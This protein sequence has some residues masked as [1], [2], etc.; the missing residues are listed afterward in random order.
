M[1]GGEMAALREVPFGL[2]Y[3]TIDATPLFIVLAGMYYQRT[4]D[5]DAVREI[6]PATKR[7]LAW[8]DTS[9]DRDGDGYLEY[10]R[11]TESGLQN[12]GWKDSFDS[13]FHADGTLAEGPIALVEVQGYA[14]AARRLAALCA[15]ALGF[16]DRAVRLDHQAEI[17]AANFEN[18]FWCEEIG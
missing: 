15:R 11:A 5:L 7:A 13:V 6:W 1:R 12:Q 18:D 8:M 17:L 4:G 9:G 10:D 3:G 2:Y 16:D 14:Y